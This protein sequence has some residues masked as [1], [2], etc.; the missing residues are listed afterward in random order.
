MFNHFLQVKTNEYEVPFECHEDDQTITPQNVKKGTEQLEHDSL[1]LMEMVIDV[2]AKEFANIG[3]LLAFPLCKERDDRYL[4]KEDFFEENDSQLLQKLGLPMDE[5]NTTPDPNMVSLYQRVISRY[6]GIHS[7]VPCK[8]ARESFCHSMNMLG[9]TERS[10]ES[11]FDYQVR[12][13]Q[14]DYSTGNKTLKMILANDDLMK[15]IKLSIEKS[16]FKTKFKTKYP[17]IDVEKLKLASGSSEQMFT[18]KKGMHPI[19]GKVIEEAVAVV[20]EMISHQGPQ[21]I[22][23]Y[24]EQKKIVALNE[25]GE[26]IKFEDI[27]GQHVENC[28]NC[29]FVQ[30]MKTK[31]PTDGS[32][33]Q[34]LEEEDISSVLEFSDE[35]HQGLR[36]ARRRIKSWCDFQGF[37]KR[38]CVIETCKLL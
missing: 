4:T 14:A 25:N 32:L 19:F 11:V 27:V 36:E 10:M 38:V 5:L 29:T 17:K 8:S 24:F 2:K 16:A 21:E 23:K 1:R 33:V 9:Q 35:R 30:Q 34:I 31:Y 7:M 20:D 37:E 3:M 6:L 26:G 13:I 12:N 22:L 15:E 18:D 28:H